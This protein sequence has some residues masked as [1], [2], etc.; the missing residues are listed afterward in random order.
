MAAY[1]A[2]AHDVTLTLVGKPK[3]AKGGKLV[4]VAQ[5]PGGL[6]IPRARHWTGATRACSAI[7]GPS[8]SRPKGKA[9][10]R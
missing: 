8:S 1:D 5:P 7:M 2:T 9:I 6:T 10:S 3:F 4:V